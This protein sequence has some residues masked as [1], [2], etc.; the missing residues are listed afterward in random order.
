M[1]AVIM[2]ISGIDLDKVVLSV[3]S[4]HRIRTQHCQEVADDTI[5]TFTEKA[6][7]AKAPLVVHFDGEEISLV[8]TVI[9]YLPGKILKSDFDGKAETMDR[10][11]TTVTSPSLTRD[12]TLGFSSLEVASGYNTAR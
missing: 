12:Q 7:E 4:A 8:F 3:A 6:K 11:V 1:F 9:Y 2:D 10:I 5:N